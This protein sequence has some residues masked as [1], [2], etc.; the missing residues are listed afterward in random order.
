MLST[1]FLPVSEPVT[2]KIS[3]ASRIL[4][5]PLPRGLSIQE[6][7]P[8]R[9]GVDTGTPPKI[10][11]ARKFV[12]FAQNHDQVG[13][14]PKGDRL[15]ALVSFEALKLAAAVVLLSP[16]IPLLFMGEEYGETKPFPYFVSHSD[17]DL[18]EAVRRGRQEEFAYLQW[19][20]APPDPQD[21]AIFRRAILDH[22]LR[23]QGPHRILYEL[24]KELASLRNEI[25]TFAGLS[26]NRM[27]V[28]CMERQS[29]LFVR[30]WGREQQVATIFH[31]GDSAESVTVPLPYGRWLKRL[32][33]GDKR[34]NGPGDDLP[35]V[36]HSD[37]EASVALTQNAFLIVSLEKEV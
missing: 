24:Y 27:E 37:G 32:A 2:T 23:H 10:Y 5:N 20:G 33:S 22:S 15:S 31:F 9:G 3:D 21:E 1:R 11:P 4:R 18:I 34:W 7:I 35:T 17:P 36:L 16:F 12:A 25:Q 13:N 8:P 19:S 6:A 14:R 29:T 26:K 28:V 30:R